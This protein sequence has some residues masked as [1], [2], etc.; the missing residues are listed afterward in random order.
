MKKITESQHTS[1]SIERKSTL[2]KYPDLYNFS[3][4]D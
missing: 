1:Q 2:K 4:Y 3:I